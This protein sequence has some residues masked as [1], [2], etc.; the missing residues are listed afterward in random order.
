MIVLDAK[1]LEETAE[2]IHGLARRIDDLTPVARDFGGHMIR[3]WSLRFPRLPEHTAAP[4]GGPPAVQSGALKN[5]L[6]YEVKSGGDEV[7]AGSTE[8]HAAIQHRGDPIR[9]RRAKALTV[10]ISP[11][12]YGKRARDFAD[13]FRI[14]AKP[15]QEPEDLGILAVERGDEVVPLFALR[16]SVRL[17]ARPWLVVLQDDWDYLGESMERHIQEATA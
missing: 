12:A 5:S 2:R 14:P 10:P 11:E 9:P 6:H 1:A 15:G 4:A 16:G 17:P 13:I 7:E 3:A 8:P